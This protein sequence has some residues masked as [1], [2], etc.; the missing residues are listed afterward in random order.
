MINFLKLT[1]E[2]A[3]VLIKFANL[4]GDHIEDDT[5][6]RLAASNIKKGLT[7]SNNKYIVTARKQIVIFF[8]TDSGSA[9]TDSL[10]DCIR[11]DK[12]LEFLFD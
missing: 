2:D 1:N 6:L 7:T 5:L 8:L 9:V 10:F 11:D 4:M 12:A 3:N